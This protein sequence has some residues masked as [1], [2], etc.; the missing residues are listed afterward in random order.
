MQK[1][2]LALAVLVTLMWGVNFAVT[3]LGLRSVDPFVLTCIRF[4][5]AALPLVFF[6]KRPAAN[7]GYV[8]A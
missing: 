6:I 2:H 7:F 8:A 3:Q 1:K 4:T 5:L